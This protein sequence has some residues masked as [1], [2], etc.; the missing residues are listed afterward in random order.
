MS[1]CHSEPVVVPRGKVADVQDPG[2]D[3]THRPPALREEPIGDS[4]LIEDLD[5]A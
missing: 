4:A 2:E 3:A 1:F 5:G